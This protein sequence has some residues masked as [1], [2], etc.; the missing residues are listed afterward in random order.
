M[1]KERAEIDNLYVCYCL[2]KDA[3]SGKGGNEKQYQMTETLYEAQDFYERV[4]AVVYGQAF[5]YGSREA[6]VRPFAVY[7]N[8]F[9]AA[10]D[11]DVE[12]YAI[13]EALLLSYGML[14][15]FMPGDEEFPSADGIK[16]VYRLVIIGDYSLDTN[17]EAVEIMIKNFNELKR[18]CDFKIC[19][20]DTDGQDR[21]G[22]LSAMIDV[23]GLA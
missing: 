14:K 22:N 18:R 21:S 16:E 11:E 17:S 1:K 4:G 13:S 15:D 12:R 5:V 2:L 3:K 9:R 10:L 7:E 20:L 19:Y 23:W 6:V 8:G